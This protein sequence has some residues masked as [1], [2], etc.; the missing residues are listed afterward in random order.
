MQKLAP[1]ATPVR[2]PQGNRWIGDVARAA[3]AY[4]TSAASCTQSIVA[5]FLDALGWHEPMVLRASTAFTAGMFSSLT[6]GIHAGGMIIVGLV[7]GRED[8]TDG[9]DGLLPS[10]QPAQKIVRRLDRRIGGHDCRQLTGVDFTD[11]EQ[12]MAYHG[13]AA[14]EACTRRIHDGAE[15]IALVLKELDAAGELIIRPRPA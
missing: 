15:E 3:R 4:K 2:I 11:L 13:S 9:L 14:A 10:V 7:A 5:A 12:A 1:S 8:I 6:C